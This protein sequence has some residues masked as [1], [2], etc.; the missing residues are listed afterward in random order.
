MRLKLAATVI[1]LTATIAA[2]SLFA[3]CGSERRDRVELRFWN[4]FAGPDGTTMLAIVKRFN[5]EHPDIHVTMQRLDWPQYY[6]KLF[7]AGLGDRAPEVFVIHAAA[8][9]RFHGAGLLRPLGDCIGGPDGLDTADFYP[10]VWDACVRGDDVLAVPLDV[11]MMGLYYNKRL[12]REAGIV[13]GNGE[14]RPPRTQEEFLDAA[15]RLTVDADGD[16]TPE[17]WGYVFSWLRTNGLTAAAQ[18]GGEFIAPDGS[19]T[20]MTHP[21]NV[22]GMQFLHDLSHVHKV[23]PLPYNDAFPTFRQGRVGMVF[24]GIYMLNDLKKQTD[25]EFG[26]AP[27]PVLGT[28]AATWADS[29]VMCMA[30]DL[31]GE[32]REAAW[33]FIKYLSDNSLDWAA[34]GQVPVR[35][36]LLESE[37][38]AAMEEQRIFAEQIPVVRY[39]PRIPYL[40]EFLAAFDLAVEQSIRGTLPPEEALGKA[41]AEIDDAIERYRMRSAALAGEAEP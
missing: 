27:T 3:G 8:V 36:S 13:D 32:T 20:T 14:A 16:G 4:G 7:V 35:R 9:E 31:D 26:A 22:A 15:R 24:E 33:T 10:N 12:F 2:A 19:R 40:F 34:S 23:A 37:R 30:Q 21:G 29:H 1:V 41:G 17:Q 25:Q 11:H 39:V 5:Q 6:N 28:Q 38:F 18:F